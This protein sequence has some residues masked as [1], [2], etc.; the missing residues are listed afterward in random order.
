MLE[1]S[2]RGNDAKSFSFS[3]SKM[4]DMRTTFSN[5]IAKLISF[6]IRMSA[7]SARDNISLPVTPT[8][9][10][11]PNETVLFRIFGWSKTGRKI[12]NGSPTLSIFSMARS[13]T[14]TSK[15]ASRPPIIMR[16]LFSRLIPWNGIDPVLFE[17]RLVNPRNRS[18]INGLLDAP[19]CKIFSCIMLCIFRK[20]E[21]YCEIPL[22][23]REDDKLSERSKSRKSMMPVLAYWVGGRHLRLVRSSISGS[24]ALSI[25]LSNESNSNG[26][27]SIKSVL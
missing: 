6:L 3:F 10:S 18:L 15:I 8:G 4:E 12:A 21:P 27:A 17:N 19:V 9:T 2:L 20:R 13:E 5:E 16:P 26:A 11:T 24:M 22:P 7:P 14:P 1:R 23:P 25:S